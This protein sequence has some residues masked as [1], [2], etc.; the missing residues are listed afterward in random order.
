MLS[1]TWFLVAV[2]L[3]PL[4]LWS[5]EDTA[6]TGTDSTA[7]DDSRMLVPPPVS[8]EAYPTE[9]GSAARSNYM[10]AG[11]TF[12]TAYSDNVLGGISTNPV[13]DVSYSIWPSI[14]LDETT[15]RLHTVLTYDPGFTF[16]QRTSARNE[17]DQNLGL[18]FS[19]RLSPHVTLSV[20]DSFHKSSNVLNQPDFLSVNPVS[21]SAQASAISVI[22]PVA[23][24]LNNT[25]TAELTYQFALNGMVGA[26]GSFTNLHY[27]DPAEVPGLYDSSSKGGSAFYNHRLSGKHYIGVTY[28]YQ[29]LLAYPTGFRAETQ[30]HSVLFFYTA[31]LKPT[32]SLSFFGGPQ[33]SDTQENTVPALHAWSPAAGASLS[34]QG[35]Q[36]SLA[37]S[38]SRAIAP[39]GGLI[40]A[41]HQD[42]ATTS[43]RRQL[44]RTLSVGAGAS[45]STNKLLF[46]GNTLLLPI[47]GGFNTGGH[48]I[49]G[50]ASLD[51]PLGEHFELGLGCTRL[52]QSYS[53]IGAISGAPNTNR[54]WVSI[55]YQFARPLGR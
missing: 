5:Q 28:Q 40:G 43:V 49:A 32:F 51:R 2:L 19:Y 35:R 42:A 37:I 26:S 50:T 8:A 36:T 54:E 11:L 24:Q 17:A 3:V 13:S 23:D 6:A 16:Y 18:D 38:Y 22:P 33:Y 29:D 12:N 20:L 31:Y 34:W 27:P 46:L 45:Y 1:R 44:T 15:P 7:I 47:L 55:S 14:A 30:T 41:V 21:G 48:T 10:R 4:A 25:G 52:H 9:V 53:D 39:G